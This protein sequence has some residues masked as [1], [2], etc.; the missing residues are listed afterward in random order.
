MTNSTQPR[1]WIS[2]GLGLL[3][4]FGFLFGATV[5]MAQQKNTDINTLWK[6]IDEAVANGKPR[7][8]IAHLNQLLMQTKR[9]GNDAQLLKALVVKAQLLQQVEEDVWMKNI[10]TFELEIKTAKEPL[11]QVLYSLTA[12]LYKAYFEEQR[13]KIYDRTNTTAADPKNP[14]T[15]SIADFN[16][17]ISYCYE[18]SLQ[19]AALLQATPVEKYEAMVSKGNSRHLRPTLYDLLAHEALDFWQTEESEITTPIDAFEPDYAALAPVKIFVKQVYNSPDSSSHTFKA[20]RLYQQLLRFHLTDSRPDALIDLDVARLDFAR[21]KATLQGK[22]QLYKE[23]LELL[24]AQYPQNEQA[25]QAGYKLAEWWLQKGDDYKAGLGTFTDKM[26]YATALE[27]AEKVAKAYPASEGG[28]LAANLIQTIK[29]PELKLETEEVNLPGMPF[30]ARLLFKALRTVYFKVVALPTKPDPAGINDE[31]SEEAFWKK[32]PTLPVVTSWQVQAPATA[33]Y[34]LHSAEV[35]VPALPQGK[36]LLVA[37]DNQQF[38][39]DNRPLVATTFYVSNISVVNSGANYFI[40]HRHT[41]Q[42]LAGAT[43]RVWYR[44]YDYNARRD[45]LRQGEAYTADANGRI[46][47]KNTVTQNNY[48]VSMR[49][50]IAT[51]TDYLYMEDEGGAYYPGRDM[52]ARQPVADFE[53]QQARYYFFT[54]RAIYRPGQTLFFKAIGLTR[55]EKDGLPKLYKPARVEVLLRN[56]NYEVVTTQQFTPGTYA[57]ISS[58]FTLPVGGLT[59]NFQLEIKMGNQSWTKAFRVEEYKRPKFEVSYLPLEGSYALNRPVTLTAK[60]IGYAGNGLDGAKLT[61]RIKRSTR[62]LYPYWPGYRGRMAGPDYNRGQTEI[63]H[64]TGTTKPDGSFDITFTPLPDL[65]MNADLDPVFSYTAEVVVTDINGEVQSAETTLNVGYK[66]LQ[67][68]LDAGSALQPADSAITLRATAANLQEKPVAAGLSLRVFALKNPGR[69]LRQ[70]RWEAPDTFIMDRASFEKDFPNDPYHTEDDY[71]TWPRGQQVAGANGQTAQLLHT[72]APNTLEPGYYVAEATAQDSAG[73][74]VTTVSYFAVFDAAKG[75]LPGNAYLLDY[76]EKGTI[77]P[78][79][80]ALFW[81]GSTLANGFVIE[82]TEKRSWQADTKTLESRRSFNFLPLQAG[83]AKQAF[84]ATEADRGGYRVTRLMVHHNRV[85]T[86]SWQVEVPWSNKELTIDLETFRDKLEP[87]QKETWTLR[88]SGARGE[89][90]AAEVLATMYDASLDALQP[91]AW[92]NMNPWQNNSF[93]SNWNISAGF[94]IQSG[95]ENYWGVEEK[96]FLKEYDAL[97]NFSFAGMGGVRQLIRGKST[98]EYDKILLS[99]VKIGTINQAG[100]KDVGMVAAPAMEMAKFTPSRVVADEAAVAEEVPVGQKQPGTPVQVRKNFNETAFFL[101]ELTTDEKGRLS[102]SFTMPE[103]LTRWKLMLLGHT[104]DAR[105]VQQTATVVT[106]KQL[107][108]TPNAPRFVRQGD[109]MEMAVKISNLS[110]RELTGQA[111]LQLLNAATLQ[112]VDGW[113]RNV[114]PNQY[115]TVAAGQSTVV[116]FPVAIPYTYTDAVVYRVIAQTNGGHGQPALSDGEEMALPVL[117]NRLL[118]TESFPLNMR[119]TGTRQ[120]NWTKFG[121]LSAEAEAGNGPEHHLLTVEYTTNPAWY[122]VQAL[123]YLMEYP[124]D[125]AEQTWNR[126]FANTL[127]SKM[128]NSTPRIKAIFEAW[129]NQSP[130]ALLS[131]LQKNPELKTALLEETPWVLQAKTEAEQKKQLGLLF[132]L[133][134]MQAEAETALKKLGELQSPNGGFVWFAGGRDDRYMTQYILTGIGHL[135]KL[136]ATTGKTADLLRGMV[137]RALP[138]ADAAIAEEYRLLKKGKADLKTLPPSAF[139][140][141]YLYMRSFFTQ[142]PVR[143]DAKPAYDYYLAQAKAHWLKLPLME[144]GMAALVLHRQQDKATA[145]AIL[146]SLTENSITHP[147]MGMYWKAF[148]NPGW[149][150]WQAPIESHA[151][152]MEAYHEIEN[153]DARIDDLKTWLLRQKQT[154][155]WK[156]TRATAEACYALL[157]R[158]TDWLSTEKTATI[159]LGSYTIS[160]ATQPAAEAGTGYFKHT[161]GAGK[162]DKSMANIS[163]AISTPEAGNPAKKDNTAT[164]GAVYWQYFEELDKITT[165]ATNL[166]VKKTLYVQRNTDRGPLL[167]LLKEGM[168]LKTGDR[169]KV[170]MEITTDRAMEYVHLKDMRASCFEPVNVLSGYKWQG[171]LGYYEATKDA[172]TN[173]F[174]NYLPRGTWV[175]EY[176]LSTSQVGNFSNGITTLQCLYAPEF[177]SNS[178]GIRVTVE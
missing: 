71:T 132:D 12:S 27:Y 70:R 66:S 47:L 39:P 22:G 138:Y 77:S 16:Q 128:A 4:L 73:K 86:L 43:L 95:R 124:Y 34:R 118:V 97:I 81:Q 137:Q 102:F 112:P 37:A 142:I 120:Y 166:Q 56:A 158:G 161:I 41:G 96:E 6:K 111:Q 61:Y 1:Q 79:E 74:P 101:P 110:S 9:T 19:N 38:N 24:W 146:A 44:Q 28:T 156:T 92:E 98:L 48:G 33:D 130:D 36:Y 32:L 114:F 155:N 58:S 18:Q 15:W 68:R 106:Q 8:A 153:S 157:M 176:E 75:Q 129:K 55:S 54:D 85:Y 11:K 91:H 69:L 40:L 30:R 154:T 140:L 76:T 57:G 50:E 170:R 175:F 145:T 109:E 172:S 94:G 162:I 17:K 20:I 159:K 141:Q 174:I 136:K 60:A 62:F 177:S 63:A 104:A 113:F 169:V 80:N 131:N 49:F 25:M 82:E 107:M 87:G 148:N 115:F 5:A 78:G 151:L 123:P 173:F 168:S 93:Y 117:T 178:E 105:F 121:K 99:E 65:S 7:S 29:K 51:P 171:G 143:A 163:V 59:G 13:W 135:Q 26:A 83:M 67:L 3:L 42:P 90:V 72:I 116:K 2:V 100:S 133:V 139:A 144:Q 149:Y 84:G 64:G 21:E 45:L 103:A 127:A 125:C 89:Q 52:Q 14:E 152:L 10:K 119:G 46:Q 167:D 147:E 23:A 108:I 150:W 31:N 88:I 122:A 134:R 160:S 165:A 53:Q 35:K 126:F 164:W